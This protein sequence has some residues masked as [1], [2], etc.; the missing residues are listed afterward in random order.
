MQT[1]DPIREL[2][3]RQVRKDPDLQ[4]LADACGE[5]PSRS[6]P[7]A[8]AVNRVRIKVGKLLKLTKKESQRTHSASPWRY[9]I[10]RAVLGLADDPD[11]A[12]ADWLQFGA[13][14]GIARAVTPG[15][16]LPLITE[17]AELSAESLLDRDA[18]TQ[19]HGTFDE[20]ID[21]EKPALEE[22]RGLVDQGFARVF[23]CDGVTITC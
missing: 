14:F 17:E 19:N 18:F 23:S 16:L 7:S 20:I 21:R 5:N 11:T 9:N 8:A 6:P 2:L 1:M 22:L 12:I 13:P 10:V 4:Q 3:L 15:G